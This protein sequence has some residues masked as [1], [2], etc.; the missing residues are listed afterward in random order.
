MF[1]RIMIVL[2]TVGIWAVS[3]GSRPLA[4]EFYR[5]LDTTYAVI[6]YTPSF[7]RPPRS[8]SSL[9]PHG[10]CKH[11]ATSSQ[12]IPA[13][14]PRWKHPTCTVVTGSTL[15]SRRMDMA[16]I[17]NIRGIDLYWF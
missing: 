11:R 17:G 7:H 5:D 16:D 12:P 2:L 8:P 14:M 6:P 15:C 10:Q 3:S 1:T 13:W 9:I 4:Q